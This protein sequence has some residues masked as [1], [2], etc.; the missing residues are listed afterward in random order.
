MFFI[1]NFSET[2]TLGGCSAEPQLNA[3]INSLRPTLIGF[4][5]ILAQINCE[6]AQF[7]CN[8]KIPKPPEK[9]TFIW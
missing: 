4:I 9:R 8:Y 7:I 6:R 5:K 1:G 3:T 2:N